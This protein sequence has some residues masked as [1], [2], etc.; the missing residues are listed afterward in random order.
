MESTPRA[1]RHSLYFLDVFDAR[2]GD[3]LG[4]LTDI[5][6]EGISILS[7]IPLQHP[8]NYLLRILVPQTGEPDHRLEIEAESRWTSADPANGSHATGLRILSL[9]DDQRARIERLVNDFGYSRIGETR[10]TSAGERPNK[11]TGES[12]IRRYLRTLFAR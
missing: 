8:G 6:L 9:T 3:P 2:T 11:L 12:P 4:Q 1:K 10:K 5:S 7:E